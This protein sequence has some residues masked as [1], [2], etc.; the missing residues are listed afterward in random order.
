MRNT[1]V[2]SKIGEHVAVELARLLEGGAERLLDDEADLAVLVVGELGAA[3]PLDDD[4]EEGGRGGEVERAVERLAGLLL[5]LV[6]HL[7]ELAVD[8]LVVE[9]AGHV[10]DVLEQAVQDVVVGRAPGEAADRLLALL[11]VVLVLFFFARHADQVEALGQRAL[12]REV[13]ERGQQFAPGEVAGGA[14][15][16]ERGGRYGEALEAGDERIVG[17]WLLGGT[18]R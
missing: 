2:S 18:T 16:D 6:E 1:W 7:A 11:A 3:E 8:G 14:E 13:V 5:A 15:D 9:R 4:G 12:V 10:A 17:H